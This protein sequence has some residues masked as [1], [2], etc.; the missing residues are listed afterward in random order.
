MQSF[1]ENNEESYDIN[2]LAD[3]FINHT[4]LSINGFLYKFSEIEFY[5]KKDDHNDEFTHGHEDQLQY[6]YFY[7]HRTSNGKSYKGGTFKGMDITLGRPNIYFGVLIR[8]IYP[9]DDKDDIICGPSCTVS[10]ILKENFCDKVKDFIGPEDENRYVLNNGDLKI[11]D[12]YDG[13]EIIKCGPRINLCGDHHEW[14]F[15]PYR[16][17]TKTCSKTKQKRSLVIME[18]N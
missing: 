2:Y 10:H 9:V 15:K 8:A 13:E 17:V 11:V 7:F 18:K 16:F 12:Y 5:L 3:K 1:I 14:R 4:A 6:G